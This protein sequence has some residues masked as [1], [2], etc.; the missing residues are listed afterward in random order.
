MKGKQVTY[1]SPLAHGGDLRKGKRKTAR[2][3][4]VKCP[5]HLVL[6]SSIAL[7]NWSLLAS[8]NVKRVDTCVRESSK[9]FNVKIHRFVN[10]G[11]H[12]HLLVKAQRKK[13]FQDF[14]RYLSGQIAMIVTRA[15]KGCSVL[16]LAGTTKQRREFFAGISIPEGVRFWDQLAFTRVVSLDKDFDRVLNY[17]ELN[18]LESLGVI[19][20]KDY[21]RTPQIFGDIREILGN[22]S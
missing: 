13:D 3:L 5:V 17:L 21:K 6:R 15:R 14:L 2:P 19:N 10:V 4:I 9:R 1:N 20:R 7:A 8:R 22:T 11:N 18:F 12:L 16:K